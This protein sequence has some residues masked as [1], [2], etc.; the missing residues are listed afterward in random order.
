MD[1]GTKVCNICRVAKPLDAFPRRRGVK[2]GRGPYCAPCRKAKYGDPIR[3]RHART[4]PPESGEQAC[5]NCRLTKPYAAFHWQQD[6]GRYAYTCKACRSERE[7]AAHLAA[8]ERRR[9]NV[10][11]AKY[12]MSLEDYD[13][14]L[15]AQGGGCAMCGATTNPDASSLAVDHCHATG[16]VRGILCGPCNKGIGLLKDDPALLMRGAEYLRGR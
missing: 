12:G 3:A 5:R 7:K 15:R 2:D 1:D 4:A 10:I 8:P 14:L 6:K 9:A 11:R 13:G 16:R